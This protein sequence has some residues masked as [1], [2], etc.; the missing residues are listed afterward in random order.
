MA[1]L[2]VPDLRAL[3][4]VDDLAEVAGVA[5]FVRRAQ[6][7]RPAFRLGTD[8]AATVA[9]ICARLDGLPLAIEL[10][11]ARVKALGAEQILARLR[12]RFRLLTAPSRVAPDRH[13]SLRRA[14]D[15]SYGLLTEAERAL[16]RSL[17]V[18]AA[19]G[20]WRPRRRWVRGNRPVWSASPL[21]T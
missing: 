7:V 8:N 14:V 20:S 10:A 12:D 4:A 17:S 13:W 19:A 9:E 1:P 16:F 15:W 6:A 2:P 3:P 18:F 21:K 5:L 11:A